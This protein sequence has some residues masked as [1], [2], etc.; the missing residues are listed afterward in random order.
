MLNNNKQLYRDAC[1]Q[2]FVPLHHQPW[3]LDAVCGAGNWDVALVHNK[4][5]EVIGSWPYCLTKKMGVQMVLPAPFTVYAGPWVDAGSKKFT[6]DHRWFKLLAEALPRPPLFLQN[7]HPDV[8]SHLP[9]HWSGFEQGTR[10]TY[11]FDSPMDLDKIQEGFTPALRNHIKQA[12][13]SLRLI[14][15]DEAVDTLWKFYTNSLFKNGIKPPA[16]LMVFKRLHAAM[17]ERNAIQIWLAVD[18]TGQAQAANCLTLD[19]HT[20]STLMS[21]QTEQGKSHSGLHVLTWNAIQQAASSGRNFDFEGSMDAAI[22]Q[23]FR[24]YGAALRPYHQIRR[25]K[26]KGWGV[27][28]QLLV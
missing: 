2:R 6:S 12:E 8:I 17:L 16:G 11:C 4:N 21:G 9:L 23:A 1:L 19:A 5:Q 18:S 7:M 15:D 10:Y 26:N 28:F 20:V 24:A 3:W 22:E 27:L 14:R 13:G 25:V